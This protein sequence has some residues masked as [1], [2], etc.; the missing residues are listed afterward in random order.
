MSL[1]EH[2][3]ILEGVSWWCGRDTSRGREWEAVLDKLHHVRRQITKPLTTNSCLKHDSPVNPPPTVLSITRLALLFE[4]CCGIVFRIPLYLFILYF[5]PD[6]LG[7]SNYQA[8]PDLRGSVTKFTYFCE[9]TKVI[10]TTAH[11]SWLGKAETG[12]LQICMHVSGHNN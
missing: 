7:Q 10:T 9:F 8:E 12:N 5:L 6:P 3:S 4:P 1:F 2:L 11:R